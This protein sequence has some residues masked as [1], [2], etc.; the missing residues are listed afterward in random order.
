M[1]LLGYFKQFD[2]DGNIIQSEEYTSNEG[3]L[4]YLISLNL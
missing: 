3:V 1:T 2:K 4:I